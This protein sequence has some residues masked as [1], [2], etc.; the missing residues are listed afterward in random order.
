M[1]Y[2]KDKW[3]QML[4]LLILIPALGYLIVAERNDLKAEVTANKTCSADNK[5]RLDKIETSYSLTVRSLQKDIGSVVTSV[6][7]MTASVNEIKELIQATALKQ[8][9]LERHSVYEWQ[10]KM[11]KIN[12]EGR[13]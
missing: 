12:R 10:D 9:E 4:I 5:S 2:F 13:E 1:D 6:D 11:N 8:K 3:M 7:K